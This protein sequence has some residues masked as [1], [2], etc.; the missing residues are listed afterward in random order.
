MFGLGRPLLDRDLLD[1]FGPLEFLLGK[2]AT[3]V[4]AVLLAF[5]ILGLP[6]G[7]Q[8]AGVRRFPPFAT[9]LPWFWAYFRGKIVPY[10]NLTL[11]S[12]RISR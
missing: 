7:L 4:A 9:I 12:G 3:E 11:I 6:K 1:G 2:L 5:L 8:G 10:D